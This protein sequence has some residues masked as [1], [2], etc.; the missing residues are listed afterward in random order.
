MKH[1]IL[2]AMTAAITLAA[3]AAPVLPATV[4]AAGSYDLT[5]AVD[6][7]AEHKAISPYIFGI[8]DAG[9]LG[10]VTV[11]AVRQGGNRFSGYNWENNY[12]NAGSDWKNSSDTY[13]VQNYSMPILMVLL[14]LLP[15]VVGVDPVGIYLDATAGNLADMLLGWA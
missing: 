11:N 13:L 9:H 14:Y 1:R 2:A 7:A 3:T 5:V 10:N 15:S 12:S 8:N 6:V 4:S